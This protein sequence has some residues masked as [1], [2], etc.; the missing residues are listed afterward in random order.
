MVKKMRNKGIKVLSY[1]IGSS[2]E[3]NSTMES[4][5]TM[6]G[7]DSQFVNVTSVME[8]AKTMNSKFL[9]K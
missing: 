4:F 9:E 3:S 2:Y 7:R 1:F 8:V 5:K 6:Y